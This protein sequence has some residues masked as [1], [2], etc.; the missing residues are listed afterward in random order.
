[1]I[2]LGKKDE[3]FGADKLKPIDIQ[4]RPMHMPATQPN[5][6]VICGYD[7]GLGERMFICENLEQMQYLYDNYARGGAL[8]IYWYA[9]EDPGFIIVL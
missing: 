7:Q 4:G 9:G 8:G 1:V 3:I 2:E 5:E 6:A